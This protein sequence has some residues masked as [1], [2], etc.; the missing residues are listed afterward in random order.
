[1]GHF[2]NLPFDIKGRAPNDGNGLY[3]LP[4]GWH[5]RMSAQSQ[6]A[7]GRQSESRT[8]LQGRLLPMAALEIYKSE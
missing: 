2:Q 1:M 4:L 5:F 3:H 8:S 7:D 6:V